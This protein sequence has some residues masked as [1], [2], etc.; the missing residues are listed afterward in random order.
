MRTPFHVIQSIIILARI[1]N[2]YCQGIIVLKRRE[3]GKLVD[4]SVYYNIE[5]NSVVYFLFVFGMGEEGELLAWTL[6][7]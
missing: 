2:S 4:T 1:Y 7:V 5:K 3:R 6:P